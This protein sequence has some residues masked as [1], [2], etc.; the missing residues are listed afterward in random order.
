VP[1]SLADTP[2]Y[3][4][5]FDVTPANLVSAL[6]TERGVVYQPDET[7]IIELMARS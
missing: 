3:N 7:K 6:I 4:P 2:V 1:T 5:A